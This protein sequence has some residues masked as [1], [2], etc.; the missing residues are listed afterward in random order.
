MA[1]IIGTATG[2]TL[3][4]T[5]GDDTIAGGG[6]A[7]RIEGG[8]G[9]D[10]LTG[11]DDGWDFIFGEAGNDTLH[12]GDGVDTLQG[13]AGDDTVHGGDGND[14]I[15]TDEGGSDTLHG[16]G[17]DDWI[18]ISRFQSFGAIQAFGGAGSDY[19]FIDVRTGSTIAADAGEGDDVVDVWSMDAAATITLGAGRD[20]LKLGSLGAFTGTTS[21]GPTVT[22]FQTGA[23]GDVF[24]I[25]EALIGSTNWNGTVN[26]F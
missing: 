20:L 19:F 26:P 4:G 14:F 9:D 13:G 11:S 17:G 10:V 2:E 1:D 6:G 16:E 23:A 18:D 7:D 24:E 3:V 22:D 25:G 8:R 5:N 12:G 15:R 21:T